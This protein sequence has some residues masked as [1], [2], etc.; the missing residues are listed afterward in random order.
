[1]YKPI[2]KLGQNFLMDY[3]VVQEMVDA[4]ELGKKETIVEIGPGLGVLTDILIKSM[5]M[6]NSRVYA[7]EIDER[8]VKKLEQMFAEYLNVDIIEADVLRWLPDFETKE[9]F[10]ILGSLPYYITSP[11][12]HE[13]I[14]MKKRPK[15]CILLIQREVADK[16]TDKAPDSSYL[17]V[18]VQTFFDVEYLGFVPRGAFKPEPRVDGG[19]IRFRLKDVDLD[20]NTLIHYEKF[21]HRGFRH[22]RKMLNKVFS[23]PE[24]QMVGIDPQS[25]PQDLSAN[26]WLE[27]FYE[28]KHLNT[29]F[30]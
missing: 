16:I 10:K 19:I 12:I 24:L 21:L 25:R 8:F 17:S 5:D 30:K 29:H 18:F 20:S 22:P 7:V 23:D 4:L 2:K 1:M 26:K 27:F 11:I 28:T 3:K 15:L 13:I 9:D 14:R 6:S